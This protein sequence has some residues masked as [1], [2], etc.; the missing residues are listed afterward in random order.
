MEV[1]MSLPCP[2]AQ[3]KVAVPSLP[4]AAQMD[5][6]RCGA[7]WIAILALTVNSRHLCLVLAFDRTQFDVYLFETQQLLSQRKSF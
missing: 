3:E 2:S 7:L 6:L 5:A 4:L 1:L